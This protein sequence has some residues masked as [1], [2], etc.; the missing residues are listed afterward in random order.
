IEIQV[1]RSRAGASHVEFGDRQI[2]LEAA[3]ADRIY[4]FQSQLGAGAAARRPATAHST[5]DHELAGAE[6]QGVE[7]PSLLQEMRSILSR[8][9]FALGADASAAPRQIVLQQAAL[10]VASLAQRLPG[11]DQGTNVT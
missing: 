1:Q 8:A 9:D 4:V 6:F 2:A 5:V 7:L 3:E 10:I 11:C